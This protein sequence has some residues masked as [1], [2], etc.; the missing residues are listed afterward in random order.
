MT[1][2]LN[3]SPHFYAAMNHLHAER[4]KEARRLCKCLSG[5]GIVGFVIWILL[6]C[7]TVKKCGL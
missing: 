6:V 7:V 5:V 2:P 3:Q 1:T 4:I